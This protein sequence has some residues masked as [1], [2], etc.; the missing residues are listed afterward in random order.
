MTTEV[1]V[2]I[3]L[4]VSLLSVIP[5]VLRRSG[6]GNLCGSFGTGLPDNTP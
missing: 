1:S 4:R 3:D 2:K 5:D 6:S